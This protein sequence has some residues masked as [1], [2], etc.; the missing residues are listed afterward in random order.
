LVGFAQ[1]DPGRLCGAYDRHMQQAFSI[2]GALL[3]LVAYA[4]SQRGKLGRTD[5]SYNLMN[6]VGSAVLAWI[7]LEGRQWGFLLLEGS[8]APLANRFLR[9]PA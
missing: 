5:V 7:A 2:A 9:T 3:I 4:A 8:W 1:R 6:L